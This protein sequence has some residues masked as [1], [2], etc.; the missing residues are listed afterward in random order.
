MLE[1]G[2]DMART[3]TTAT[4]RKTLNEQKL[5]AFV[6]RA[7]GDFGAT[8]GAAL[9]VIGDKL[10]LYR[11]LAKE[12][13]TAGELATATRASI[14]YVRPWCVQQAAGGVLDY[15]SDTGKYSLPPEHAV[16]LTDETSPFYVMGGFQAMTAMIKAEPRI[17]EGFRTGSG[18][19]WGEHDAGLFEGTERFF[20]PGYAANLVSSWIP[21]ISGMKTRLEGEGLVADVGC[22][23]AAS[24]IIMAKAFPDAR[25]CGFASHA[26][27]VDRAR[28]AASEANVARNTKFEVASATTFGGGPYDLICF[29]DSLHDMGEPEAAL[30]NA[31]SRLSHGG[32]LMIVEPMAADS[33][34][35]N[36]NPVGRVF[37]GASIFVCLPNAIATGNTALGTMAS[38]RDYEALARRAG[39]RLR[40][41][42]ETPFNRVF[43][44]RKA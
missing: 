32:A 15:D 11:T 30:R 25:F 2:D 28:D 8:L 27:S 33:V 34:E 18:M 5:E 13:L 16:A 29:F 40:R 19:L 36:L 9:T 12:P 14:D 38:D 10:G 22:G 4:E 43:E 6:G 24:T 21:A 17:A 41:A 3:T 44:A 42:T 35:Q 1:E 37:A 39:L 31:A 7:I 20:R 23:H 26:P